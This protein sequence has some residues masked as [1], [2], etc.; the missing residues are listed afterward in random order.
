VAAL[1]RRPPVVITRLYA[2]EAQIY[3]VLGHKKFE[4]RSPVARLDA[5]KAGLKKCPHTLRAHTNARSID[6]MDQSTN[7]SNAINLAETAIRGTAAMMEMQIGV[8]RRMI[9]AQAKRAAAF[10]VPDYSELLNAAAEGQRRLVNMTTDQMLNST[11]RIAQT[12][13]ELHHQFARL[14]EQQS[15]SLTDEMCR[16]INR[17]GEG[18]ENALRT[19]EEQ[20]SKGAQEI[21][22][23]ANEAQRARG[24]QIVRPD[25]ASTE[26]NQAKRK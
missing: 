8:A 3:P 13:M 2:L 17:L 26:A 15:R 22:R 1:V 20:V 5:A 7:R 16:G 25:E 24:S 10:G 18:T 9:D 21:E 4:A 11:Q 12:M 6:T 14:M 19:A 23:T